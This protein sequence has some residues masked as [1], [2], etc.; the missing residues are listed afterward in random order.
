MT[1]RLVIDHLTAEEKEALPAEIEA[2]QMERRMKQLALARA[3]DDL[4]GVLELRGEKDRD[5]RITLKTVYHIGQDPTRLAAS[6]GDKLK[7]TTYDRYSCDLVINDLRISHTH[8]RLYAVKTTTSLRLAILQDTSTNGYLING[9]HADS[10]SRTVEE[11]KI[12]TRCRVLREGDV[13][14]IPGYSGVFTYRQHR[15]ARYTVPSSQQMS[16][17]LLLFPTS[18]PSLT[19]LVEPW[20]IHNYPLG[21]GSWGT[22]NLGS[23]RKD[24]NRV[25]VAIKTINTN[26]YAEDHLNAI[27]FEIKV[28]KACDHP[29]IL[30]LLDW[31]IRTEI[32]DEGEEEGRIHIV[33]E[34]VTGGDL[35]NYIME[36]HHLEE[37][38]VRWIGWQMISGLQYLHEKGIVHR[39]IKPENV[40]LHTSCAYP[41][42]YLADFGSSTSKARLLDQLST[43]NRQEHTRYL[44][45]QGTFEYYS[46]DCLE[47]MAEEEKTRR[48]KVY[49][50]SKEQ[51]GKAWWMEETGMDIWA[52]GVTL[53]FCAAGRPPYLSYDLGSN[54]QS[55]N[56]DNPGSTASH[57]RA[58][59]DSGSEDEHEDIFVDDSPIMPSL[60]QDILMNDPIDDFPV[61]QSMDLDDDV[62][63]SDIEADNDE[64]HVDTDVEL[65]EK[66]DEL[67]LQSEATR[68]YRS[69]T[70]RRAR[71]DTPV[72]RGNA[73]A[74]STLSNSQE[75]NDRE[76]TPPSRQHTIIPRK[77]ANEYGYGHGQEESEFVYLI[78]QIEAFKVLYFP[79][80]I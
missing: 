29:N 3:D 32:N 55:N 42:I 54:S 65:E 70:R 9:E 25:Q 24:A 39:D 11:K 57:Q 27:K 22:V 14:K 43:G 68:R 4:V 75:Q 31:M 69:I 48:R 63:Y 41:R 33:S 23:H 7:L 34:L 38:E 62:E 80:P 8:L 17:S 6:P 15:N 66:L 67:N 40:L 18:D 2:K 58:K 78:R 53:Y 37:S 35:W 61:T 5:I 79:F 71:D 36:H 45:A 72:A 74:P 52:M 30:K 21:N 59:S 51:V 60:T 28:Q 49:R 46:L 1:K 26:E 47:I 76:D 56:T 10:T 77:D 64:E 73:A 20:I 13:V 19:F 16:K 44:K 12:S 50:G